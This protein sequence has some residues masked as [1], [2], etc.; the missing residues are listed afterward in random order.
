M[1]GETLNATQDGRHKPSE[2]AAIVDRVKAR[3]PELLAYMK[4]IATP[5]VDWPLRPITVEDYVILMAKHGVDEREAREQ[6]RLSKELVS[7]VLV[8]GVFYLVRG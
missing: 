6:A 7:E 1:A 5:V 8:G 4:T 2:F 3:K